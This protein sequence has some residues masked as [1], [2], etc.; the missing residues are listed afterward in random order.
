MMCACYVLAISVQ[1]D[2]IVCHG[3]ET[4]LQRD[5]APAERLPFDI[6]HAEGNMSLCILRRLLP[7]KL[8]RR[9]FVSCKSQTSKLVRRLHLLS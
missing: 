4:Q 5:L 2:K 6:L 1:F 7:W 8:R 9:L 3:G